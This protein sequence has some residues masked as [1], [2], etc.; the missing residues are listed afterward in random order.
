MSRRAR[1]VAV[2]TLIVAIAGIGV[3][4]QQFAGSSDEGLAGRREADLGVFEPV[5]GR[6]VYRI[7]SHLEAIDP[8]HP[9]VPH[10]IEPGGLGL[11]TNAMPAGFY[12]GRLEASGGRPGGR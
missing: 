5:R 7:G 6:I 12:R 3:L 9:N 10:V 4:V 11:G 8:L 1:A 2:A